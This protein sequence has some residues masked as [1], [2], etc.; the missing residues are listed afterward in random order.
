MSRPVKKLGRF[1]LRIIELYN[2]ARVPKASAALSYYLTMTIF[3][4]IIC[5]YAL[6]G[7]NYRSA[8]EILGFLE[9]FLSADT[10]RILRNFLVHVAGNNSR[11]ILLTGVTVLLT[12]SSAAV[13]CLESTIGDMQGEQRYRGMRE[14]LFSLLYSLA[15]LAAMYFAILVMFTGREILSRI[16]N[17]LP[18]VDISGSWQWMRFVLL[19][20]I[21]LVLFWGVYEASNSRSD[22]CYSFPGA[23]LSTAAMVVVSY[24]FS[25]FIAASTRYPLVYGS[26]ASVILLMFWLFLCCQVILVGA[27]FNVALRDA[28]GLRKKRKEKEKL[29]E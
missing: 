18:F 25:I 13:R 7:K 12:S 8:M 11:A 23:V 10:I 21:E 5:L 4:L 15:F 24:V 17:Y 14:F 22:K 9:Q 3:P 2:S 29:E 16:N 6:L 1:L 27:A 20:G 19:G 26:L 28:L